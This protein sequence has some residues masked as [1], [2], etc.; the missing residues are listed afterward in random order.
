MDAGKKAHEV[1]TGKKQQEEIIR[2]QAENQALRRTIAYAD[3]K[4]QA[5]VEFGAAQD[6]VVSFLAQKY[7]RNYINILSPLNDSLGVDTRKTS[8]HLMQEQ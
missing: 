1:N 8:Q 6:C 2:L 7:R 5:V 4:I 3:M